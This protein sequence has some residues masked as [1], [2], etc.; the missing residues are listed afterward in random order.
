M[1]VYTIGS[2]LVSMNMNLHGSKE[3]MLNVANWFAN[4]PSRYKAIIERGATLC[5][6]QE[7]VRYCMS[8]CTMRLRGSPPADIGIWYLKKA[9]QESQ[10]ELAQY[11]FHQAVYMLIRDGGQQEL[12]APALAFIESWVNAYPI[13]Q[14]GWNV[15][16]PVPLEKG[17]R[18]TPF[19]TAKGI[20]SRK[21][22]KSNG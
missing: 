18:S 13:F 11:Y 5:A 17:N 10:K 1:N 9:A 3:S 21:N 8:R 6:D 14:P 19:K 22:E 12:T 16:H 7:N 15:L 2:A 20:L 4:R